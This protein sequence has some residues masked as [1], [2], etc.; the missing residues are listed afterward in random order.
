[1]IYRNI[2]AATAA[3]SAAK[4]IAASGRKP[5][6]M[7]TMARPA[8]SPDHGRQW[9]KEGGTEVDIPT[10]H[11]AVPACEPRHWTALENAL[12]SCGHL[13]RQRP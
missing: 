8:P 9:I 4:L 10:I 1:M 7:P 5:N 2:R 3:M 12:A 11:R 6:S 13:H